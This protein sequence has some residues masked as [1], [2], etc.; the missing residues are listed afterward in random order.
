METALQAEN[1]LGFLSLKG[2]FQQPRA[3]PC[4]IYKSVTYFVAR[5]MCQG[6]RG[7]KPVFGGHTKRNHCLFSR[8]FGRGILARSDL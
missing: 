7:L 5:F 4:E 2:S 1:A 6:I 8:R 3:K